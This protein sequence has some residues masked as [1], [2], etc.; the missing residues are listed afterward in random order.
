MKQK[1]LFALTCL[2]LPL[3]MSAAKTVYIPSTWAYDSST[4]EY[5][6]G[7]NSDLQWSFNRSKQSDNCIVFW[8]KGF[9]TNP[10]NAVISFDPDAV[11]Q[12]AE[13]CYAKNVTEL[14]FS[15]SNMLNKYKLMILVS[16]TND[17]VCYGGGYDFEV[18]ALWIGPS[19][20]N[21]AGHSLGHE[22]GHSFHYMCY[23]EAAN[24]NHNSSSTNNTGFHLACG[25]GQAIWEQTAQWQANQSYPELMF[26][27]SYPLFGNNANYAFSHEWMRYQSY[28]FHYY[29]SDYYNDKT[30]VSQIWKQPMTEQSNGN[31]TDFCQAY[32]ALKGLTAAQFYERYFD[33]A[34]HCATFDFS[35]AASYRN[36]YIG[37]FDY[38][39]VQ[40]GEK[41]YQV[42]Y[43]SAP[44]STGFN[45]IELSVP[46]S[47]TTITTKFTAL[48]HGCA[49]QADDPATYNNGVANASVSAGV[50]S[51]NS[52]GTASYRGFRVGY[53]FLKSDGTRSYYND[54][55]VHCTGT[56]EV[57]ENI[58]TT[59][60]ANTSRI[61]LVV[62]PALTTYVKHA[63]DD[64]ITNDD[65]WPYSFELVNTDATNA[66]IVEKAPEEPTFTK[67][68][69]GRS[70]ADVTLTYKVTLPVD[71]EGYT[72]A[73]VTLNTGN[74]LNAL[75][76][77]FQLESSS[78]FNSSTLVDYTAS[79]SN[80]TIMSCAVSSTGILQTSAK[81]TNGTYGH[82]FNAS[83]TVA[84]WG[85]NTVAFTE[86]TDNYATG[87]IGQY[88]GA[89]SAG[90]T[91]TVRE[92]LVYKNSS[93]QTA[94]AT[95]IYNIIFKANASPSAYLTEIDYTKPTAST[96]STTSATVARAHE[97]AVI[98]WEVIK[99]QEATYTLT[100]GTN[101]DVSKVVYGLNSITESYLTN[102]THFKGYTEVSSVSTGDYVYYYALSQA[103][104]TSSKGFKYYS[105]ASVTTDSVFDTNTYVHYY[106]AS[107]QVVSAANAADASFK[108][109][110]DYKNMKFTVKV[111]EDCPTGTYTLY[112]A[113]LRRVKSSNSTRNY[114]AYF[115]ITLTVTEKPEETIQVERSAGM[116][117]V[118]TSVNVDFSAA[119][120][121]LGVST[122][123]TDMLYFVSDDGSETD[124]ATYQTANNGGTYDGWCDANGNAIAWGGNS[125]ICVKFFQA[126]EN[127]TTFE[128]CDMNGADIAGTSYTV[129]WALK[130]GSKTYTFNIV[131]T[132]TEKE[133]ASYNYG[134]LRVIS[135]KTLNLTSQLGQ[136]WEGLTAD[137]DMASILSTLSASSIDDIAIY[138]VL[139][140]GNLDDMYGRGGTDG[141]RNAD[142]DWATYGSDESCFYVQSDF[143]Q[144]ETQI[145][146]AGGKPGKTDLPVTYTATY[147]FVS[148]TSVTLD[149]VILKVNLIYP[150]EPIVYNV[151]IHTQSKLTES[152]SIPLNDAAVTAF[153]LT[154][155]EVK[156]KLNATSTANGNI[157]VA[158]H[159][160]AADEI[161]LYPA[162]ADGT[163]VTTTGLT[164]NGIGQGHAYGFNAYTT[165]SNLD[166]GA[167][168]V[169]LDWVGNRW[170]IHQ[171]L[172]ELGVDDEF[173]INEVL[174]YNDGT[175]T[176]SQLFK[177]HITVTEMPSITLKDSYTEYE[178][179]SG[180]FNVTLERS[181]PTGKWLTF[182]AP[183]NIGAGEW[184]DMGIERVMK[185]NGVEKSGESITLQFVDVTD[186]IWVGIPVIIK[187]AEARTGITMQ[188]TPYDP[189][190]AIHRNEFTNGTVTAAIVSSYVKIDL[191]NDVY[192]LQDDKFRHTNYTGETKTAMKGWRAYFTVTDTGSEVKQLGIR[193]DDENVVPTDI[194]G[195]EVVLNDRV[196]VYT[197]AGTKVKSHVQRLNATEG[198]PAGIYLVGGKKVIVK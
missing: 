142:G 154:W 144:T 60:P 156:T 120:T 24:Y 63:W 118:T 16:Y 175:G 126:I 68:I 97:A 89:N 3:C 124:Y 103:P 81:N 122:L 187:M 9:G 141:Y 104:T 113:M 15:C 150:G 151:E 75:C 14:G 1:L 54:N 70:I 181:M 33:Y 191:P 37:K 148:K 167:V 198:L 13:Q 19:A 85:N 11:L 110:Y 125:K 133:Y 32:I 80:N 92:A 102:S 84:A 77:A 43:H 73:S 138:A 172:D 163:P 180:F 197:V 121:Y 139:S 56:A 176:K 76:T 57:T 169:A 106:N 38:H 82:W 20:V 171:K 100:T 143:S 153:G 78:I 91:R 74:G 22:V 90:T 166:Q 94:R 137:V 132:F 39:A 83:G 69:D 47:G 195:M 79:Q 177:F 129:K 46:S 115:P 134:S 44:Q 162:T 52:A 36:N 105:T 5:T 164:Y 188:E 107:G 185:L 31:A 72:G 18:S 101:S 173:D 152:L 178:Q 23:A 130:S 51:Y 48:Q 7:G 6:E 183:F 17:W 8:Q 53:V 116:G 161:M 2:L 66:T 131:T 64:D 59:V 189:C 41:K 108:I 192:Y 49:L 182:C 87:T 58:S 112:L 119:K 145:S 28:W 170:V 149:A 155:E 157:G 45:V 88:P 96:V 117:Y 179:Q 128:I 174:L 158:N 165:A 159:T 55:T 95:F 25:N 196:D 160:L 186:G 146:G 50:S 26:A 67:A 184:A 71:A 127:G 168:A 193:L 34:L 35:E 111:K 135:T 86:F 42:A 93:G 30:I 109:G 62:A 61:F 98:S 21:P 99:G 114:S 27:E 190:T 4:Q 147:A 136:Y 40:L 65:Q 10:K 140:N 123:S 29:L 12:V 194:E